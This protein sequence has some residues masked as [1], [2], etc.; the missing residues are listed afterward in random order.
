MQRKELIE[1]LSLTDTDALK[2]L[3]EKAYRVKTE[4]VGKTVYFR[5]LIEFSNICSKN[6]YYCGIRGSNTK[7]KRFCMTEDEIVDS[8]VWI[9]KEGYGSAVLQSGERNTPDFA[10]FIE[11]IITSIMAATSNG[12]ALTLCVG[13]QSRATY[14][15]WYDAGAKR[16]LLRIET[17]DEKFY[18][19][20]HPQDHS[21]SQRVDCLNTLRELGYMTGTGVMIGLP[22]QTVEQLA[23]DILFF[24]KMDMDMIGMGPYIPHEDTPLAEKAKSSYDPKRNL[25]LGLKMIAATRLTLN[26]AN[27]AAT[28]AL[29]ALDPRGR[30]L[31]LQAGANVIMPNVTETKYRAAYQLYEGKPCLD[32]NASMCRGCLEGRIRGIGEE[33]GYFQT[34]DPNHYFIRRAV[35]TGKQ[36]ENK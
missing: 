26:D 21:F 18:K 5:G 10:A 6:C 13:E 4:H 8:A 31:G 1:L 29:Q 33:I 22:G 24:R 28:T 12:L 30:E 19:T 15:R 7:V 35:H 25:S 11:R 27:I 20:L 34:G 2:S 17:S 32:E 14:K 9:W 3:Y 36:G 16:Y 23:D